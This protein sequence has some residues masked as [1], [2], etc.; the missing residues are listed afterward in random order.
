MSK[1]ESIGLITQEKLKEIAGSVL[2]FL[3]RENIDS[4]G[5]LFS[6]LGESFDIKGQDHIIQIESRPS[7]S[8]TEA[9]TISYIIPD[10]GIP[11]E[12]R[13]NHN[14]NYSKIIVK[15]NSRLNGYM[16]FTSD[17]FGNIIQNKKIDG[18]SI[19]IIKK[20]LEKLVS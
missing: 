14:F 12:I 6:R 17:H 19:P 2:D 8:G 1:V 10:G 9:Y 16:S 11:I 15:T 5:S 4:I 3:E 7:E 20:E 13:M 18:Y